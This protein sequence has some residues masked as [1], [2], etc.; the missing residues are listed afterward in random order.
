MQP[1]A[2][3][4]VGTVTSL[5]AEGALNLDHRGL[6]DARGQ[7]ELSSCGEGDR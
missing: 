7:P 4:S 5:G 2:M 3:A 6:A 1:S